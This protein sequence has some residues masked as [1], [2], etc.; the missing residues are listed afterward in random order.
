MRDHRGAKRRRQEKRQGFRVEVVF[1]RLASVDLAL[2]RIAAR[3]KQGGHDVTPADV[4]RRF[5]RGW[6]NFETAY[7]ALADAWAVYDNSGRVP[8]L[9]E[10]GP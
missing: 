1:L 5:D 3:V 6:R 2:E 10:T 9:L 8:E 4:Q 7:R